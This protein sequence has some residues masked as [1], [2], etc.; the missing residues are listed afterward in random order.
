[1]IPRALLFSLLALPLAGCPAS[2]GDQDGQ[3][4]IAD[5]DRAPKASP[6]DKKHADV[7]KPL[8]GT[9]KGRFKIY[10]D[11]RGQTSE[12]RP[13]TLDPKV[14]QAAPYKLDQAIDV[15]QVY[16]SESPYFQRVTITDTYKDGKVATSKGIN[17]VQGGKLYC[18]VKKP[19]DLVIHDGS[20]E[21]KDTIIWQRDRKEPLAIEYFKETVEKDEYSILGWGYYGDA[22][23]SLSPSYYFEA[24]Y[25]RQ[26]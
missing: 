14:W 6:E 20:T 24:V 7:F 3:V 19:D 16:V 25:K 23:P 17:K 4:A 12:G 8:D 1:M 26:K 21:G 11:S 22:D 13:E 10:V 15:K 2:D 18:I 5:M 9:W